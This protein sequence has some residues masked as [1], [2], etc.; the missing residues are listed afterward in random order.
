MMCLFHKLWGLLP[1]V[2]FLFTGCL[3]ELK[4]IERQKITNIG[5]C[6]QNGYCI[7]QTSTGLVSYMHYPLVGLE[8]CELAPYNNILLRCRE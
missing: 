8:V 7:V 1:V 5:G 2:L 3:P 4:P 6:S